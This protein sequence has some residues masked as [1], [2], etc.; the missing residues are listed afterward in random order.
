MDGEVFPSAYKDSSDLS[1]IVY[2]NP[3][4][5]TLPAPH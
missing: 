5:Q 4:P 3:D 1:H 2:V